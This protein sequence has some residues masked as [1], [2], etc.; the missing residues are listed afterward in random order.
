MNNPRETGRTLTLDEYKSLV[1]NEKTKKLEFNINNC[2]E[3]FEYNPLSTLSEE[4]QIKL[5]RKNKGE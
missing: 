1:Y 3:A 5:N 2:N 4:L